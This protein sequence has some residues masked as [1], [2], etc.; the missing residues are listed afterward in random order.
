MLKK[1]NSYLI[2]SLIAG[3]L[4]LGMPL[5]AR[6]APAPLDAETV[7]SET[8]SDPNKTQM[9]VPGPNDKVN[10]EVDNLRPDTQVAA[11]SGSVSTLYP[12]DRR[13]GFQSKT[14]E[15]LQDEFEMNID[16]EIVN[17]VL[18]QQR[19][20]ERII[21]GIH[22]VAFLQKPIT[23]PFSAVDT[24]YVT[25]EYI[26]TIVF[27]KGLK[28]SSSDVGEGFDINKFDQNVLWFQ[29]KRNFQGTNMIVGL[30][31]GNQNYV[32][33][34]MLEKYLPGNIVKDNIEERYLS[35]GEYISTMIRYIN[36]PKI[37]PIEIL[38]KYFSLFG[39]NSIKKFKKNGAFDV[40]TING[41][42]FYIIRDDRRGDIVYENVSFRISDRYEQFVELTKGRGR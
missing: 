40:I 27:P 39:D 28:I 25:T 1:S 16:K 8:V 2:G 3:T 10:D 42:P 30:T 17:R 20:Y 9:K 19:R 12:L 22:D 6:E 34:I 23:K 15:L 21:S 26:T 36:P 35:C 14:P 29:P 18:K 7:L 38:K 13:P 5:I 31:D 41:M 32:V 33:N 37:R 11:D 4:I 24:I